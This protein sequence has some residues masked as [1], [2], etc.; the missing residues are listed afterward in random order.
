MPSDLTCFPNSI[1]F[2]VMTHCTMPCLFL[3]IW[4]FCWVIFCDLAISI[5]TKWLCQANPATISQ[6]NC[7]LVRHSADEDSSNRNPQH[8]PTACIV[9]SI[10]LRL[11]NIAVSAVAPVQ[12]LADALAMPEVFRNKQ[13]FLKVDR[14]PYQLIRWNLWVGRLLR[15][16]LAIRP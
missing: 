12:L 8:Q 7:S 13:H 2:P 5:S 1:C 10:Y 15:T 11:L 3:Q 4:R 14:S 6:F 16:P 9:F